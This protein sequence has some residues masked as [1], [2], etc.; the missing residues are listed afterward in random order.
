MVIWEIF[1]LDENPYEGKGYDE[2]LNLLKGGYHLS[3]PKKIYNIANWKATEFYEEL[4]KRCF[5]RHVH[6]RSSFSQLVKYI[7]GRLRDNELSS[8]KILTNNY[9]RKCNL[10]LDETTRQ[11]LCSTKPGRG[12][13]LDDH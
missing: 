9:L 4:T 6:E 13:S 11:R 2:L 5:K 3:C 8:Y 1:S 7:E 10:L 12:F